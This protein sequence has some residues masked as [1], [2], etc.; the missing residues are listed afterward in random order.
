[1]KTAL[2]L[3]PNQL[4]VQQALPQVDTIILVEDPLYFGVDQQYPRR[5][6]KQRLILYRA[7]MRRYIEEVLWPAN[8]EVEYINLDV[9]MT[10]AD[11]L[12]KVAGFDKVMVFEPV[13]EILTKRLLAGRRE[14][15]EGP[16]LEFLPTPNFY[17][18]DHEIRG[19]FGADHRKSF[20]EFYQW[21]RERFN[22]LIGEDYKPVGGTWMFEGKTQAKLPNGEVPPSFGVF[23]DND[24]VKEA[25]SYVEG[26]FPNNPGSTDFIW[27]TNHHEAALWLD[28]FVQNRLD[29]FGS[30]KDMLDGQAAW[31]YHSA[32]SSS[33]NTG[34]L[35][36]QQVV[37]AA[38]QHHQ[39]NP[40]E[41]ASLET[42]VRMVLG[43]REFT[44]AQYS[45][46][47]D[48]LRKSNVFKGQRK[49]TNAWFT[50][51]LGIPPFDDMV[52]KLQAH[53]YAHHSE[54]LMIAANLMTLCEISPDDA[55]RWFSELFIDANDWVT[56]PSVYD[57]SQFA[58]GGNPRPHITA[59]NYILQNS[60][61]ERGL[62]TDVWDGL[63]WRFIEKNADLIKHNP[64]L[65]PVI[66]RMHRLDPD[67]RRVISYRAEDFLNAHTVQ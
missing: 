9:F 30:Y 18:Q 67:H 2:I 31:L 60:N 41:L 62:W 8:Y 57:L 12:D 15:G 49:L 23:G 46:R 45:L 51:N 27:P 13:D 28:D 50:G 59:S 4:F 48:A 3:Y 17:L 43:Q 55:H 52:K 40:V 24:Y 32:L 47:A 61:Y 38:L 20:E 53:A 58:D 39:A 63:Y 14:R 56:V 64:R 66:Q 22:I 1:M 16:D 35:S 65:R 7:S 54:R 10:S 11:V 26:H 21:Q 34:L 33:L 5:L 36:P 37:T 42:F 25:I 44:R 6:H 29:K 19:F